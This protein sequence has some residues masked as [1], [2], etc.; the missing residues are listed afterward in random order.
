MSYSI[1]PLGEGTGPSMTPAAA[2][3]WA[4]ILATTVGIFYLTA[5]GSAVK[6][7]K[8]RRRPLRLSRLRRNVTRRKNVKRRTTKKSGLPDWMN[9]VIYWGRHGKDAYYVQSPNLNVR[10]YRG[11]GAKEQAREVASG[12]A[13]RYGLPMR[14]QN[15]GPKVTPNRRGASRRLARNADRVELREGMILTPKRGRNAR[16]EVTGKGWYSA[17][18]DDGS[19]VMKPY[20]SLREVGASRAVPGWGVVTVDEEE[21]RDWNLPEGV[22]V[23]PN[24]RRSS[25]RRRMTSNTRGKQVDREIKALAGLKMSGRSSEY[26]ELV[27]L[28]R[29]KYG[30][31]YATGLETHALQEV[32]R[33]KK[34]RLS[35]NPRGTG[36]S[37]QSKAKSALN[38]VRRTSARA[39]GGLNKS[40]RARLARM[41]AGLYRIGGGGQ[42][43]TVVKFK[44]A[45]LQG[46]MTNTRI[47]ASKSGET[48]WL[49]RVYPSGSPR[50]VVV[51]KVDPKG[52]STYRVEEFVEK[53]RRSSK[54]KTRR[55]A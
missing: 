39:G 29:K 30:A 10:L 35:S 28:L 44:T 40:V 2:L 34:R 3:G 20:W 1:R 15:R 9:K 46:A 22:W 42:N 47:A 6:R 12:L 37:A 53:A 21:L 25:T 23:E 26:N 19:K 24:R 7:N 51:R 13:K 18:L 52:K 27:G 8:R 48:H 43:P 14:K 4:A 11:A 16:Y 49:V 17:R 32:A 31:A 38:E 45:S 5:S 33:L 50:V 54:K 41:A 55:A 36:A